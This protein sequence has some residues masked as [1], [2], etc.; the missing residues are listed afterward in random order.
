MDK[1]VLGE[2][3]AAELARS[4]LTQRQLAARCGVTESA[5]SKYLKGEREPKA[6]ILA[7]MATALDTTTEALLGLPEATIDTP[8]GEVMSVCS[9][10][11]GDLTPE[12]KNRIVMAILSAPSKSGA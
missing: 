12:E 9:R 7:N 10:Y 4:G 6:E 3:I 11:A 5:V 8:Y 1:K 2:R